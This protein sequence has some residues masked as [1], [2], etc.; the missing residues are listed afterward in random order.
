MHLIKYE[1]VEGRDWHLDLLFVED[2]QEPISS[3]KRKHHKGR[4]QQ[5]KQND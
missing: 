1:R 4:F 3:R 2:N 5:T